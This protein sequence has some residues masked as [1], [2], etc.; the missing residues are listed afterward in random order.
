MRR[1]AKLFRVSARFF[2][3]T[4][5]M[6]LRRLGNHKAK[7]VLAELKNVLWLSDQASQKI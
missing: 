1:K 6:R 3:S 4:L 5:E 2:I 7:G